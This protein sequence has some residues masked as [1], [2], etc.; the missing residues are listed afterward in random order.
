MRLE[1][2]K[3][4]VGSKTGARLTGGVFSL[5]RL[6]WKLTLGYTLVTVLALLLA[7]LV[8]L[9]AAMGF[10]AS[11]I[12][13]R[14]AA[15]DLSSQVAPRLEPGLSGESPDKELLR[16]ELQGTSSGG[17]REPGGASGS[18]GEGFDLF[19]DLDGRDRLFVVDSERTLLASNREMRGNPEGERLDA[20]AYPGL[21]PLLEE[22]LA[23]GDNPW[24]LGSY[25]PDW[26]ELLVAAPV[27]GDDGRVLGAAVAV[28]QIPNLTGP[29]LAVAAVG[30]IVLLGPAAVL[31]AIFGMLTAW[32]LTRRLQR[33]F[34]AAQAWSRGDFS[35]V[36]RD[37]SRDEIGQLARELN[38]MARELDNLLQARSELATLEA[39]NRFARE[40]H[41][42]VKQQVFATSLQIAAAK[43]LLGRD[44]DGAECH[45]AQADEL[46]HGAQ[47]ELN[48]M[49]QEMRP[50][51]LE[52][53]GLATAVREY[54]ESWSRGSE[55][56][57]RVRVR[58]ERETPLEVEQAVFRVFQEALSNAAR[59][60]GASAVEVELS[61][62]GRGGELLH[63]S[64]R[65][66]GSGFATSE[67]PGDGFGL[68]SMHERM[69]RIGGRV[70]VESEPGGG[71][72]V[73]C[74]C[75]LGT[76]DDAGEEKKWANR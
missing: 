43:A 66:D 56:P 5:R 19:T 8:I 40:L 15:E 53:K 2:G 38:R 27:E 16:R 41:D 64:V 30:A 57:A 10:L 21:N 26:S 69:A 1:N 50:A 14:L 24:R 18:P 25:S 42:S 46:V 32:S 70:E 39:R 20:G 55:I 63:L 68:E 28:I 61:W 62:E 3:P 75:N 52:G 76:T 47:K 6:R 73:E 59:H 65:D 9:A 23:G 7:E 17:A 36:A 44:P 51:A 67:S 60:S 29:L 74:R 49:I 4:Q 13:P 71:T 72:L 45:L 34:G 48:A 54:T 58:G 35:A 22:A 31:G 11:P 37:R 12:L 33:L